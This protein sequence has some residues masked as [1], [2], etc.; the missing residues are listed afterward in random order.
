M[1]KTFLVILVSVSVLLAACADSSEKN[2]NRDYVKAAK[3]VFD[4]EKSFNSGDYSTA[5][6]LCESAKNNVDKIV[7][8]YPDA[9]L[10]LKIVSDSSI[11]IGCCNYVDL[12]EKIIPQLKLYTSPE[13]KPVE[14]AW[15]LAVSSKSYSGLAKALIKNSKKFDAK[16]IDNL[17]DFALSKVDSPVERRSLRSEYLSKLDS[18][19][20]SKKAEK[21][22]PA[23]TKSESKI[24]D[25]KAFIQE[26]STASSLVSYDLRA[27]DK[28][29]DMALKA[30]F[31]D[32]ET[33]SKF[34]SSLSKAYD[35]ILKISVPSIR[36]KALMGISIAF[37]NF[38]NDL[39]AIAV[40]HKITNPNL[41]YEVFKVIGENVSRGANY[42]EALSLAPRLKNDVERNGFLSSLAIGVSK[43][44]LYKQS[45]EIAST[46]SDVTLRNSAYATSAKL[47]FDAGENK[48][49]AIFISSIDIKSLE[50]L[51][52]F[53]DSES[54][55]ATTGMRLALLSSRLI[56]D[57]PKL[58]GALN[59]LAFS[60]IKSLSKNAK[61]DDV[62]L[63]TVFDNFVKLEKYEIAL[64]FVLM[65][66][67]RP[68]S[69]VFKDSL[70]T[71]S[72]NSKDNIVKTKVYSL[73]R[74]IHSANNDMVSLA[75][76]LAANGIARDESIKILSK[77]LPK[78]A[79]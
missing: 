59:N 1:R 79:K 46:I 27:I 43:Q 29:R 36:E 25:V 62:L 44:G 42:K 70:F 3:Q 72:E 39:L 66:L 11:R 75:V 9:T 13:M 4:A 45:R 32:K 7:E 19:Q 71:L 2:A 21:A 38:G 16:V 58:A 34:A 68:N 22:V 10:S 8:T 77:S 28:L 60:E 17:V 18:K 31:A 54:N 55:N 12:H 51:S 30:R 56:A 63:K 40:S 67:H 49:A 37:A 52:V 26:A 73:L 6:E 5:L 47:A 41:F 24:S 15:V 20:V 14:L 64:D 65:N 57:N 74:D 78:F 61:V 35:N 23:I 50:C 33:V 48:E 53:D 69:Y 76:E